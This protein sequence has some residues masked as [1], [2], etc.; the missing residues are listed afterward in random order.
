MTLLGGAVLA[1]CAMACTPQNVDEHF[2]GLHGVLLARVSC[3]EGVTTPPV[4]G[5]N[6]TYEALMFLDGST[7]AFGTREFA[8]IAFY[9]RSD[10]RRL[11]GRL[12]LADMDSGCGG[13]RMFVEIGQGAMQLNECFGSPPL[14]HITHSRPLSECSGF[15]TSLFDQGPPP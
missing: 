4:T 2:V 8:G 5:R 3:S 12:T 10:L 9:E 14:Y 15:N 11:R 7:L 6:Y 13:S 1:A